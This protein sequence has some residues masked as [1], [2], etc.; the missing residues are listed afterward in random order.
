VK[1]KILSTSLSIGRSQKVE[2]RSRYHAA[3]VAENTKNIGACMKKPVGLTSRNLQLVREMA[4][5]RRKNNRGQREA[6]S[7][8]GVTPRE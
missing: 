4:V 5:S 8:C 7:D 3:R 2:S 1:T 6:P